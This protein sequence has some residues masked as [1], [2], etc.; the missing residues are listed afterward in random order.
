[1]RFDVSN[2]VVVMVDDNPHLD[3]IDSRY[4]FNIEDFIRTVL[5]YLTL[6]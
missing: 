3:L 6:F 1:M 4:L 2:V 5:N